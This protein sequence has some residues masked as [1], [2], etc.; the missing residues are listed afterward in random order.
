[1][2]RN[3]RLRFLSLLTACALLLPAAAGAT[4]VSSSSQTAAMVGFAVSL[5]KLYPYRDNFNAASSAQDYY[6][7][8]TASGFQQAVSEMTTAYYTLQSGGWI[9][10][11]Y[12]QSVSF[13]QA[14]QSLFSRL[15]T[16]QNSA[17][18][19]YA[20]GMTGSGFLQDVINF[21][22]SYN[23]LPD[24]LWSST[25]TTTQSSSAFSPVYALRSGITATLA[26]KM[27][28]RLGPG[29]A[30]SEELG[31]LPQ[32]TSITVFEQVTTNG[33][34][35]VMVEYVYQG[36]RYRAWTGLKR[37]SASQTVPEGSTGSTH[38]TVLRQTEAYYG[39]GTY[40]ARHDQD[41]PA[42]TSLEVYETENGFLLCDY[43]QDDVLIRAYI[44]WD[45]RVE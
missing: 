2:K 43:Y 35:W 28:T 8:A 17:V 9:S 3:I 38:A 44:P 18:S 11:G 33:V 21:I 40:Y 5:Q 25:T 12:T 34:P 14:V 31:T 6:S 41:V 36:Q 23:R 37:I 10:T 4:V 15:Y 27:A 16:L 32:D 26:M 42:N 29:T 19:G 20:A 45:S 39:P 13:Q 1:M 24:S 7:V 30:Y 22:D